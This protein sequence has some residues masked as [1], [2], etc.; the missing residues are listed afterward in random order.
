MSIQKLDF[1]KVTQEKIPYAIVNTQVVQKIYN[2]IAL[3]IWVYLSTLPPSWEVNKAQIRKHFG[4]SEKGIKSAM[5]YLKKC[6][7]IEYHQPTGK[8]GRFMGQTIHVLCGRE[9]LEQIGSTGGSKTAPADYRPSG[10]DVHINNYKDINNNTGINNMANEVDQ[11]Q[12]DQNCTIVEKRENSKNLEKSSHKPVSTIKN[13]SKYAGREFLE[14]WACYPLHSKKHRA[15][16][17]FNR[18]KASTIIDQILGDIA[19][20]KLYDQKWKD[21]YVQY[22]DTYLVQRRWEDDHEI[23]RNPKGDTQKL[24]NFGKYLRAQKEKEKMIE[25]EEQVYVV[26]TPNPKKHI[27]E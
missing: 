27:E 18:L 8:G 15:Y 4:I 14:F 6:R 9:F 13:D 25:H 24:S 1:N 11:T 20:R 19:W 7:L 17:I 5:A 12:E 10:K 23:L 21:G 2:P 16:Q 26:T 3:S 22:P